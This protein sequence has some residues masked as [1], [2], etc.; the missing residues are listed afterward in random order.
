MRKRAAHERTSSRGRRFLLSVFCEA[1]ARESGGAPGGASGEVVFAR[2]G[3][4]KCLLVDISLLIRLYNCFSCCC[5]FGSM[6]THDTDAPTGCHLQ[7]DAVNLRR[8]ALG[9]TS[10]SG[11][12]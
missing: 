6:L 10:G 8:L 9:R 5:L 3:F 1:G 12:S 11:R 7:E 2:G 4:W